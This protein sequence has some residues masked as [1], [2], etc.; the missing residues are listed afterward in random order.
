[1]LFDAQSDGGVS[2]LQ[3]TLPSEDLEETMLFD[4]HQEIRSL[5]RETFWELVRSKEDH[6]RYSSTRVLGIFC[7][8]LSKYMSTHAA[9]SVLRDLNTC[10]QYFVQQH[11]TDLRVLSSIIMLVLELCARPTSYLHGE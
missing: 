8:R 5:A 4:E 2:F 1:M 3:R 9:R 11:E 6:L 7:K 10:L